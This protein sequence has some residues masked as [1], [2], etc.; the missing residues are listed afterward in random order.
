ME[1]M[2]ANGF[3]SIGA[4]SEIYHSELVPTPALII[5]N[6]DKMKVVYN[7]YDSPNYMVSTSTNTF[8]YTINLFEKI[9]KGSL[10]L[11]EDRQRARFFKLLRQKLK[12]AKE[13][14]LN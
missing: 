2:A 10:S 5:V 4:K 9:K 13:E 1:Y 12:S 3:K 14:F 8:N 6:S 11:R 7:I